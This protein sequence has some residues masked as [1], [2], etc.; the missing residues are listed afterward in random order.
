[1]IKGWK[2]SKEKEKS[3]KTIGFSRIPHKIEM[4]QI[5]KFGATTG[6]P[7]KRLLKTVIVTTNNETNKKIFKNVIAKLTS[8]S[9]KYSLVVNTCNFP[10]IF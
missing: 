6:K 3:I 9:Y 5:I 8:S 1:M 4:L 10:V 7:S 2:R